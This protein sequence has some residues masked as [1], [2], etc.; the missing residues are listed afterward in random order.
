MT[1]ADLLGVPAED[2]DKIIDPNRSPTLPGQVGA[3]RNASELARAMEF[4]QRVKG[5]FTDCIEDRRRHPREDVMSQIAHTR[6]SDGSLPSVDEVVSLANLL[7]TAGE[8]TTSRVTAGAMRWIAEDPA[9]QSRL[10]AEPGLIPNFIEESVRFDG[11][12][13]AAFRMAKR[14]TKIADLDVAPGTVVLLLLGA[15]DR[16]PRRF[17]APQEVRPDRKNVRDHIAFGRGIHSCAG[18]PIARAEVKIA[19]ERLLARIAHFEIDESKHGPP[20]ARRYNRIPSYFV[21]GLDD[22]FLTFRKA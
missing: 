9:L 3:D 18:A 10:R 21:Q 12:G 15:M 13:R 19:L 7:F 8:D 5:Y 17:E 4:A 16:D 11:P 6:Y 1:V 14:P 2:Y 20:D 22:L